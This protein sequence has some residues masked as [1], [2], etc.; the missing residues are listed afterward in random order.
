MAWGKKKESISLSDAEEM[1]KNPRALRGMSKQEV[2]DLQR[3][4]AGKTNIVSDVVAVVRDGGHKTGGVG[5][6]PETRQGR[7]MWGKDTPLK[8]KS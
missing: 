5:K 6:P 2:K 1:L 4:A 3:R 7:S 8:K